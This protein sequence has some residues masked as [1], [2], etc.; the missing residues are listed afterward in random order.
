MTNKLIKI[1]FQP[2]IPA[3]LEKLEELANDLYY[4]WNAET[5]L[6]FRRLDMSLWDKCNH[7]PKLFLRRV[8][9]QKLDEAVSDNNYM[10]DYSR[11]LSSYRAYKNLAIHD[12]FVN[13]LDAENDLIAYL[14]LEFG[15]HESFPIYSGGL[16]ILA[17]DLCKAA[18][19]MAIPF[20]GVGLLY[21]QGY[22]N[23]EINNYGDQVA[24]YHLTEF[25]HLPIDPSCDSNGDKLYI[26]IELPNRKITLKVWEAIAGNIKLYF[27]DSDIPENEA[28]DREI[29]YQLYKG[30]SETRILQEIVLGIGGVRALRALNIYPTIW[31][32]NEGHAAFSILERSRENITKGLD[33]G[34]A[35][36]L[37]ASNVVF[38]THTPVPA[39]HD[40]FKKELVHSLFSQYVKEL[41][42]E[43]DSFMRLGDGAN[44]D[45]FNMTTLALHCSRFHN[46][47]SKIHH[48]V[49]SKMESH[50][51]SQISYKENPIGYVTN[52]VHIS[53]FLAREWAN[54]FDMRFGE[55]RRELNNPEFWQCLDEIP[56]HRFW[57]LRR[58][59]KATLLSEVHKRIVKQCLRNGRSESK[60]NR[61]THLISRHDA[62]VLVLGFARRFATYKRANLL[63]Y[64]LERLSKLL[65]DSK[66]PTILIFAGKAHPDDT[67]GRELV[68]MVHEFTQRPE[69]QGKILH[70]EN[71]DMVL[72]RRLV[73]GVD[74]WI[75]TPEYP[76]EA[77][78]TSGQKAG[79]NGVLNLSILDGWW[80]EGYNG[81]NGWAITP[82]GAEFDHEYRNQ[83][84]ANDLLEILENEVMPLYFD[85][86][87][88]G[89]SATWVELA[90]ES[91]KS[92]IPNFNAQRMLSDYMQSYYLPARDKSKLI[93]ANDGK[94][95]VELNQWKSKIRKAW[96]G[97]SICCVSDKPTA[98]KQ[99]EAFTIKI[100]ANLNGLSSNDV[101]VECVL[102]DEDTRDMF[103][104]YNT[105]KFSSDGPMLA[106]EQVFK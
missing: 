6:L 72:A 5:R 12:N 55:W 89:Y 59:L 27:L 25:E 31:H 68:K 8:A 58:E 74:V 105:Y 69:F 46:G 36:E 32:T 35:L 98:V 64:D 11:V 42:I 77:C 67:P 84:E 3:G 70:V 24:H 95:A 45:D 57:S 93:N 18:S 7:N 76:M 39:G 103:A 23:Q 86:N 102:S 85:R 49:A 17:G 40:I 34:S 41:G 50:A 87:G 21:R 81:N 63:F 92:I 73:A 10:D 83:Q 62:D 15:F 104:K 14:C 54:L 2:K 78:G 106:K 26:A 88:Q 1:E 30:G 96:P 65:N 80:D 22:F 20:V 53:T 38:T 101:V 13:Q 16:G 56:S 48:E 9:Q 4:S 99:G 47:V 60:I 37:N 61:I 43:F 28:A 79:M 97:V 44:N 71:Y 33:F 66:R 90:K 75:N 52:G 94:N 19:D 100:K 51:W 91:M 29:T 82:H